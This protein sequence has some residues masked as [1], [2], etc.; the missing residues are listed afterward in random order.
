MSSLQKYNHAWHRPQAN[1]SIANSLSA[2][3]TQY[4]G[5]SAA[6]AQVTAK[7]NSEMIRV[8]W[9]AGPAGQAVRAVLLLRTCSRMSWQAGAG[10][11]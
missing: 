8:V 5:T 4:H 1:G 11:V 7:G 3:H 10:G 9:H 2:L 6:C